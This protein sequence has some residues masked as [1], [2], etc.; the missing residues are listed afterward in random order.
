MK[1]IV[2]ISLEEQPYRV[3]L[4][5]R[6]SAAVNKLKARPQDVWRVAVVMKNTGVNLLYHSVAY[7]GNKANAA[8]KAVQ[9]ALDMSAGQA[10]VSSLALAENIKSL[11]APK[12]LQSL[13]PFILS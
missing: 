8:F 3:H 7:D 12:H 9:S 1:V 13:P 4:V 2:S 5:S 6:A 10:A 11:L